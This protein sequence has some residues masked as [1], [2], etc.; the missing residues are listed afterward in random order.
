[1]IDV[2]WGHLVVIAVVALIVIGPRV[3]TCFRTVGVTG[4]AN[5]GVWLRSSRASSRRHS[6]AEVR[7]SE[8]ALD[9]MK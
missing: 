2:S 6:R 4:L 3:P 1:M 5:S 8:A 9:D 7:R